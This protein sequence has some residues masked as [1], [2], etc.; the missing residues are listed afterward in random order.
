[1]KNITVLAGTNV[2]LDYLTTRKPY[3]NDS[4]AILLMCA[5]EKINGYVAFHSIPDIY[6]IL[7]KTHDTRV[8]REMLLGICNILT[9]T[10]ASHESVISAIKNDMFKDLEDCLQDKCAAEVNADY[11]I[12]RNISDFKSSKVKAVTPEQFLSITGQL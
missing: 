3:F 12:T 5:E 2:L 9:V 11:I 6:Y 10:S 4:Y 1:M 7:R 8:R